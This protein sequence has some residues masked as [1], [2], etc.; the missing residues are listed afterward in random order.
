MNSSTES[1]AMGDHQ[2]RPVASALAFR[3]EKARFLEL[4][5]HVRI[6]QPIAKARDLVAVGGPDMLDED[7]GVAFARTI[8]HG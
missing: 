6:G 3:P 7:L 2:E 1:S 8:N 5:E 4:L